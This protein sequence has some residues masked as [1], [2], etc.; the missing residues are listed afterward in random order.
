MLRGRVYTVVISGVASPAA[1]FD[2]MELV[3]AAAKPIRLM[4]LRISQTSEPTTEEEQLALTITRG[5]TVSGSGG[6]SP[7]PRPVNSSDGAAGITAEVMNTTQASGGTPAVLFEDV[8]NTRQGYD[9][10]FAPDEAIEA[11]NGERLVIQH[12]APADSVTLRGTLWVEE[13]G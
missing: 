9:M 7:T 6:T 13:Q 3:P 1:A 10:C 4:R 8:W 12:G 5:A 11:V 2:L